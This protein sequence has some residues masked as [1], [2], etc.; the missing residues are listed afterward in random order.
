MPVVYYFSH[1][2]QTDLEFR[3]VFSCLRLNE[4]FFHI[5]FCFALFRFVSISLI[6]YN[7]LHSICGGREKHAQPD[8]LNS[9]LN[10]DRKMND[11][12]V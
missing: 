11:D 10:D 1:L 7:L 5:R 6:S 12:C 8:S 9:D 2:M 3:C 4:F